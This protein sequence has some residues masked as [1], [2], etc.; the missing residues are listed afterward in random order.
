M[1][2][3]QF[4]YIVKYIKYEPELLDSKCNKMYYENLIV[5]KTSNK[6]MY[7]PYMTMLILILTT[8]SFSGMIPSIKNQNNT[9]F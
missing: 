8:E 5:F 4:F 7:N 6:K 1:V 3:T 2:K 9:I